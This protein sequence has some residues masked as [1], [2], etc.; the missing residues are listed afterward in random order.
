MSSMFRF[1]INVE[2]LK[3]EEIKKVKTY[4]ETMWGWADLSDYLDE[5]NKRYTLYGCGEGSLSCYTDDEFSR[6]IAQGLWEKIKR[7]VPINITTTCLEN[8]PYEEYTYDKDE[9]LEWRE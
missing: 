1:S 3:K 6:E 9:Y 8:L 7:F 2:K 5:R 4:L